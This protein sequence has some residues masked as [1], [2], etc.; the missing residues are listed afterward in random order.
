MKKTSKVLFLLS[1]MACPL[2]FAACEKDEGTTGYNDV[3][4]DDWKKNIVINNELD[5]PDVNST[6]YIN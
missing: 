3:D 2:F 1:M 5:N 6:Y 4:D